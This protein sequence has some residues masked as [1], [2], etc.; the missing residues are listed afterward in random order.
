MGKEPERLFKR[1]NQAK[2]GQVMSGRFIVISDVHTVHSE[3]KK[4]S[5]IM[6]QHKRQHKTMDGTTRLLNTITN[7]K[8]EHDKLQ[9]S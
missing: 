9:S 1:P 8:I 3:M 6:V 5:R 4:C 2:S 7:A